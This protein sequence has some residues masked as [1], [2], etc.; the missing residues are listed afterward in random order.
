MSD[1]CYL[2]N[3]KINKKSRNWKHTKKQDKTKI[4]THNQCIKDLIDNQ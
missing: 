3:K 2:C 4:Y 1:N